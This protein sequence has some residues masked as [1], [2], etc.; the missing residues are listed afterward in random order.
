[1]LNI[2]DN[3]SDLEFLDS[4]SHSKLF[5]FGDGKFDWIPV[6]QEQGVLG[7]VTLTLLHG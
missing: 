5:Y 3:E 1:M 6:S 7:G 2:L 4:I